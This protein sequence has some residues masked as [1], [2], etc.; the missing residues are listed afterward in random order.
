MT[1]VAI[2]ALRVKIKIENIFISI[3]GNMCLEC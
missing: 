1:F 3:S 2:G